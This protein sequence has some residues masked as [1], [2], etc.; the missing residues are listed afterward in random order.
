MLYEW[1]NEWQ[2][3]L[4]TVAMVFE[5]TFDCVY[6]HCFWEALRDQCVPAPYIFLPQKFYSEEAA[7]L[8]AHFNIRGFSIER[9]VEQGDPLSSYLYNALLE[10]VLRKLMSVWAWKG[11]WYQFGTCHNDV[12]YQLALCRR[13]RPA[14][15]QLQ[16]TEALPSRPQT[17]SF[18]FGLGNANIF[19]VVSR[20]QG[21]TS[22][23]ALHGL[24]PKTCC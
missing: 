15:T 8:R 20:R 1:P 2:M 21:R 18:K 10:H 4:W 9:G 12:S 7:T 3:S 16:T 5:K 14:C 13:R 17:N 24:V 11:L 6:H 19:T 23:L 22:T